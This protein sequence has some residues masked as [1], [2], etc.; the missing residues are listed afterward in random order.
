MKESAPPADSS[1][2]AQVEALR[3]MTVAQ[4]RE[5]WKHVFG[6]DTRNANKQH[7]WRR[8][9]WQIQ[10]NA[11]GGL[12]ERAQ[13][14]IEELIPEALAWW[15]SRRSKATRRARPKPK[16]Q[17]V[18]RDCRLPKPGTVLV[19]DYKGTR[20]EIEVLEKGFAYEG[21]TY[22]SLSAVA[23]EI[24]GAHWNGFLF[25]GLTKGKRG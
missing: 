21:R 2:A 5:K 12:S 7:L 18:V 1:I 20:I 23:A 15:E 16:P 9:A 6:E 22:R 17:P 4:L 14:R 25:F 19:R 13:E 11:Y 10:A 8:L 24:T 3:H